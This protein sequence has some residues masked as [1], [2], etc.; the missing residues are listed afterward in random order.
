MALETWLLF[1]LVALVPVVSP[2][3]AVLLA[4]SNTL[5]F[6]RNATL[7]SATGNALG[8]VILGFAIAFGFGAVMATSA[9]AFTAL[10]LCGAAYLV[11]LGIKVWRDTCVLGQ[12]ETGPAAQKGYA[13]LFCQALAVSVT[14]PKA[15][16]VISALFPQFLTKGGLQLDQIAILSLTYAGLCWLNHAVIAVTGSHL[17][18]FITAPNRMTLVRRVTG[19]LFVSFGAAMAAASR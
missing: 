13:T 10:K 18:R 17:R 3:P 2:G 5:R 9:L 16:L 8:L 11:Y 6:G 4:I 7:A 14:N 19:G 1:V 15:I 12:T